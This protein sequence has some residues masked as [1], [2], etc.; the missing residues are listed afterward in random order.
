M[1]NLLCNRAIA[2]QGRTD[3][4]AVT[5]NPSFLSFSEVYFF[6]ESMLA[7]P[8]ALCPAL[9]RGRWTMQTASS[10]VPHDSLEEKVHVSLAG[11][12][13]DP[14][15]RNG[16]GHPTANGKRLSPILVV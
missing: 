12:G 11:A 6:R 14:A 9:P 4:R 10:K 15:T 16:Q 13:I 1:P 7:K 3:A 2:C 5:A 8:K